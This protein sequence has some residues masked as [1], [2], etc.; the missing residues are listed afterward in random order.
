MPPA[1]SL[2]RLW[3]ILNSHIK[4]GWPENN[5]RD[6][7]EFQNFKV[8]Q[9]VLNLKI[10]SLQNFINQVTWGKRILK[11]LVNFYSTLKI[12]KWYTPCLTLM[13]FN[14]IPYWLYE[15]TY[16]DRFS[17]LAKGLTCHWCHQH[18]VD[19]NL[20]LILDHVVMI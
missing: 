9:P 14:S 2:I 18:N 5:L 11:K 20:L 13:I 10:F 8:L 6:L 3:I 19:Q 1:L 12:Q 17:D 4:K 7:S 16:M 15:K